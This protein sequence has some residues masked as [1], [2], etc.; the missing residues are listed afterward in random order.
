MSV[1]KDLETLTKKY[2]DDVFG[3]SD[4]EDIRRIP[5]GKSGPY[6]II[7]EIDIE[8]DIIYQSLYLNE[9]K[10]TDNNPAN[11]KQY[12]PLID[13]AIGKVLINGLGIGASLH[14]ILKNDA[15]ESVVIVEMS[16]DIIN[17]VAPSFEDSRVT[18]INADAFELDETESFDIVWHAIWNTKEEIDTEEKERLKEKY[19]SRCKWQG[20]LF[21]GR[22]GARKGA[23]RKPGKSVKKKVLK[24]ESEKRTV[25]KGVRYT[26]YEHRLIQRAA[27]LSGKT[28]SEIMVDGAIREAKDIIAI[29]SAR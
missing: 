29:S 3:V 16:K 21:D 15:V 20:F 13:R 24:P 10:I 11:L 27:E 14:E 4:A 2:L 6:K 23:G 7:D 8:N 1:K 28:E 12:K 18:I 17:L 25:R 19:K 5:I 22:G 9:D 26:P